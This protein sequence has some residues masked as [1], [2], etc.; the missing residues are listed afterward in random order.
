MK[1]GIYHFGNWDIAFKGLFRKLGVPF[2]I[3]PK[4]N[5]QT[6]DFGEKHCPEFS[7]TPFKIM[8]GDYKAALEMG[9]THLL[10][11]SPRTIRT[12]Q[13]ANFAMAHKNIL[14]G[15]GYKFK[16]LHREDLKLKNMKKFIK[17]M[18][19][20]ITTTK[21]IQGVVLFLHKV[22]NIELLEDI[23]GK[24][25]I[26]EGEQKAKK[27]WQQTLN[28][29]DHEQGIRKQRE[30]RNKLYTRSIK[31]NKKIQDHVKIC[32]TGDIYTVNDTMSTRDIVEKLLKRKIHVLKAARHSDIL[33][34]RFLKSEKIPKKEQVKIFNTFME[35]E[36]GGF[37]YC[38]ISNAIESAKK[39]YD[40]IIQVYP[41]TCAPE[42]V[43]KNVLPII[44]EKY[45][46]PCLSIAIGE[47]TGDAGFD[48]R[49][50][51]FIDLIELNR[52]K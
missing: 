33:S 4:P 13:L 35:R 24:V 19:K 9:A 36:F 6:L 10:G 18:N 28:T 25:H 1:V 14:E 27:L 22:A 16:I 2:A 20:D 29:I 41:F 45:K 17:T 40:G 26:T 21:I 31:L 50:E 39:N 38:S 8:L 32:L 51:A 43:V 34:E 12:C 11:L 48:T 15:Q 37:T 46:T 7:C 44:S 30:L 42:T 23:Y 49:L 52:G 5:K 47:Q 3:P